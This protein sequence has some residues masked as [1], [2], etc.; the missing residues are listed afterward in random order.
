MPLGIHFANFTLPG[1]PEALAGTL[2]DTA[3][4]ADEGGVALFTLMDHW[5][6]METL[7]TAQDPM[8]EG[9]TALGID[10]VEVA[11][12]TPDPVG[13]VSDLAEKVVPRLAQLGPA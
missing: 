10:L 1:G 4:V 5:F 12:M 2:A 7:A 9:Y 8:L 13:L 6:Q 11:P 3:R